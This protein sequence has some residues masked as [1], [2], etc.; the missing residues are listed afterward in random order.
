MA[1]KTTTARTASESEL[2]AASQRGDMAALEQLVAIY[3]RPL[4]AHCYRMLGSLQERGPQ[5]RLS[6]ANRTEYFSTLLVSCQ[7]DPMKNSW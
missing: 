1:T 2:L 7:V 5:H 3:R 4:D 6:N